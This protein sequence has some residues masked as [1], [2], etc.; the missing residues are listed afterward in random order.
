MRV[1]AWGSELV[2]DASPEW[3]LP[4]ARI[5][6]TSLSSAAMTAWIVLGAGLLAARGLG[7]RRVLALLSTAL[8]AWG[9]EAL[10]KA[11][12]DRPR[13]IG[14]ATQ[15][16]AVAT[17]HSGSFPSGHTACA[18]ILALLAVLAA[19]HVLVTADRHRRAVI[20]GLVAGA[21]AVLVA[22]TA[23]SRVRLGVHHPSDVLASIVI[24]PILVIALSRVLGAFGPGSDP[25]AHTVSSSRPPMP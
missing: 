8:G 19:R 23:W 22:L 14:R 20:V 21:G 3:T 6:D 1:D 15:V 24:V 11:V 4:L 9:L 18:V 2:I 12:I 17:P 7:L 10:A 25:A 5:L 13:P 16:G